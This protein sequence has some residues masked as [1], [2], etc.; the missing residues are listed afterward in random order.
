MAQLKRLTRRQKILLSELQKKISNYVAADPED[1]Q[2]LEAHGRIRRNHHSGW[3]LVPEP[4]P[5]LAGTTELAAL[6]RKYSPS[7]E[8][9]DE[10]NRK[11]NE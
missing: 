11:V 7:D 1:I 6:Q 5:E 4:A 8:E 3:E 9:V 10:R 2:A